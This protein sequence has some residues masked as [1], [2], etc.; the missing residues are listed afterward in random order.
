MAVYV[1][2]HKKPTET[3]G[4]RNAELLIV[5]AGGTYNSNGF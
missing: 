5:E 3:F 2:N 1:Y 4:G